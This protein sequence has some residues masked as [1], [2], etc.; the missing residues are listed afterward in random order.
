MRV[1]GTLYVALAVL[2]TSFPAVAQDDS[3]DPLAELRKCRAV[4]DDTA[5]LA[6]FDRQAATL[7]TAEESG[8]IEIVDREKAERTRKDLF[9]FSGVKVPFFEDGEEIE[10]IESTITRVSRLGRDGWLITIEDGNA[11]W[12]ITDPPMRFNAPRVGD[13][14]TIKRGS[15]TSYFIRVRTQLGV[16][17]KRVE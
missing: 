6:C 9:G 2:A 11:V 1:S 16:K 7:L 17:G 15:L 5:R 3:G 14:V 4:A 10:E 8:E 13:K 12:R